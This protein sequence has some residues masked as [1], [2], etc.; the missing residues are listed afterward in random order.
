MLKKMKRRKDN[1]LDILAN[2]AEN[3]TLEVLREMAIN[4]EQMEKAVGPWKIMYRNFVRNKLA[5]L[6]IIVFI[7]ILL[8]VFLGPSFSPYGRDEMNYMLSMKP[9]TWEH[10]LGTDKLGRDYLTRVMYGGRISILVG[11]LAAAISVILGT[12]FGGISGYYG[13]K[14]DN[15]LMRFAE[16]IYCFPFMPFAICLSAVFG[17][18]VSPET[19]MYIIMAIIGI[20]GWPSLARLIRG[21][22]LSL[23][24]E[25]FMVAAKALGIP[26]R[27][28]IFKHLIPN[29]LGYIIV[30][31]TIAIA[32]AMLSEA[33][34]SYLGLG[35]VP[36]TPS[37]GNMIQLA[38]DAYVL[39]HY[40]W[41]WM[42]PGF[43]IFL[44][45]MCVNL[46][47]DGLRD[48]VDPKSIR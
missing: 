16:I 18:A 3:L 4:Q 31:A 40:W 13:G 32:G 23:K 44:S 6:G 20:L 34:L 38:S 11:F 9:P 43:A 25:E 46:F 17:V 48:A 28:Q 29:T 21:Q 8:F 39:E 12:I 27:I 41:I 10:W 1:K 24:E 36:P 19:R 5:V 7:I 42:P 35:I 33:G 47:G 15:I 45:V 26:D 30:N 2:N 14:T 37:W 22:V